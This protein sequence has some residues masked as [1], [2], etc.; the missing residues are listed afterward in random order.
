MPEGD[1]DALQ[2]SHPPLET[3]EVS[4]SLD[5]APAVEEG[6]VTSDTEAQGSDAAQAEVVEKPEK[7]HPLEPKGERFQ[8]IYARNKDNE[9]KYHA[10]RER[11]A[12]LEGEL[13]ALKAIQTT[14][15]EPEAPPEPKYTWKQLQAAIDKGDIT[16]ADAMEY[17]ERQFKRDA[18][19]EAKRLADARATE[20]RKVSTVHAEHERFVKAVPEVRDQTS[21][22]FAKVA[23]EFQ[24]LVKT[25]GWDE[26][27]PRTE[28]AALR[29]AFGDPDTYVERK[30]A[31]AIPDKG[32]ET[33]QEQAASSSASTKP[34]PKDPL[35]SLSPKQKEHYN[36][37]LRRGVYK[38]WGE[39]RDELTFVP[40]QRKK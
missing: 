12:R 33:M 6:V 7:V 26:K 15:K 21:P 9:A 25:L 11:A 40:G 37:M 29:Q 39:I 2:Q 17:K 22:E 18:Q 28:V 16:L 23:Q 32:R 5:A 31:S 3:P 24:Y 13:A 34:K 30:K 27:D 35:D 10:E 38:N 14:P 19:Q 36:H 4:D 8:Q 20:D 1:H